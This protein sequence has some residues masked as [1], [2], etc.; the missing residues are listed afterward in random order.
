MASPAQRRWRG[1]ISSRER[2]E[3]GTSKK[4]FRFVMDYKKARNHILRF[5]HHMIQRLHSPFRKQTAI[6]SFW[7]KLWSL[8]GK[9]HQPHADTLRLEIFKTSWIREVTILKKFSLIISNPKSLSCVQGDKTKIQNVFCIPTGASCGCVPMAILPWQLAG[10]I[11]RSRS[12]FVFISNGI[13]RLCMLQNQCC[14][15]PLCFLSLFTEQPWE[16]K[17]SKMAE[18]G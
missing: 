4:C 8:S 6:H 9:S 15:V 1:K 11:C 3:E 5:K 18:Q 7:E 13:H 16:S 10:P 14:L 17:C 12:G 2:R